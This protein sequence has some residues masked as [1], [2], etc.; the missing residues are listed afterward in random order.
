M[1]DVYSNRSG[2][3]LFCLAGVCVSVRSVIDSVSV[4]VCGYVT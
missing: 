1:P 4:N 2:F 3:H